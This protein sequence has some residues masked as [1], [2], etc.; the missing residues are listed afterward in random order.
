MAA[1]RKKWILEA[2]SKSFAL[3]GYKATTMEQVA[4]IAGVGKGTI[5]TFFATKEELFDAIM[6]EVIQEMKLVADTAIRPD[7]TFSENLQQALGEIL[8]FRSNHELLIKLSHEINEMGTV[9]VQE[10]MKQLEAAILAFIEKHVRQAA[11][12]GEV[13][14]C[15][16]QIAAFVIMK[17]YI[18]F[19]YDWDRN[20][21]PL[22]QQK[23]AE[24]FQLF[25]FEGLAVR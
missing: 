23:I 20:H 15:D 2:A 21:E 19:V 24:L 17:L 6:A 12:R 11:G 4:R 3:F 5:Y 7:L 22:T 1:D 13:R 8:R 25:L 14:D 9:K 18:S 16:P 10:G